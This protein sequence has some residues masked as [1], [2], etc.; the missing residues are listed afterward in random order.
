MKGDGASLC[1]SFDSWAAQTIALQRTN[2]EEKPHRRARK[3]T[4]CGCQRAAIVIVRQNLDRFIDQRSLMCALE[5]GVVG[6]NTDPQDV[7]GTYV[8]GGDYVTSK[9]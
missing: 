6:Y 9:L 5:V 3:E 1:M 7:T 4:A 2:G 8:K